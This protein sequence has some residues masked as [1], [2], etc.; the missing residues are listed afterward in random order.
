MAA[1]RRV[2]ASRRRQQ[3]RF[4]AERTGAHPANELVMLDQRPRA[5]PEDSRGVEVVATEFRGDVVDERRHR[6]RHVT[7]TRGYS[8]EQ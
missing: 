4:F 2:K 1:S 3:Q 6:A 7:S 5:P 8:R